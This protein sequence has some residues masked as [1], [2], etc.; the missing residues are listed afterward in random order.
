MPIVTLRGLTEQYNISMHTLKALREKGKLK[1][2]YGVSGKGITCSKEELLE[3]DNTLK[4]FRKNSIKEL[5]EYVEDT[6][7]NILKYLKSGEINCGINVCG[8]WSFSD[9]D[10]EVMRL[11]VRERQKE[12]AKKHGKRKDEQI[13]TANQ[14]KYKDLEIGKKYNIRTITYNGRD[15]NY[16]SEGTKKLVGIYKHH[17][18]FETTIAGRPIRESYSNNR[19]LLEIR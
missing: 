16:T 5:K 14:L 7:S 15:K 12:R 17:L 10:M 8:V 13:N 11:Y 3:I 9:G 18:L 19:R 4:L 6:Q 1:L 2:G